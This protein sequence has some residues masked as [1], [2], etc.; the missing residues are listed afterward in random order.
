MVFSI[1]CFA[2]ENSQKSTESGVMLTPTEIE[3]VES[4]KNKP[5]IV[6][7]SSDMP[8]VEFYD[9]ECNQFSGFNIEIYKLISDKTGLTFTFVPR[10]TGLETKKQIAD[11]QIQ[12][13][14]SLSNN[15]AVADALNVTTSHPIYTNTISLISK[16]HGMVRQILL[17]I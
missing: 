9:K 3:Y 4:R 8:P 16:T 2:S 11:N 13:V 7:V 17:K 15:K 14:G 5:L 10:G 1:P 12:I 6:A